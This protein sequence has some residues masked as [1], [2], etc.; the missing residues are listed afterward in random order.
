MSMSMS[1]SVSMYTCS[2]VHVSTPFSNM[3]PMGGLNHGSECLSLSPRLLLSICPSV[4]LSMA[5]LHS[6]GGDRTFSFFMCVSFIVQLFT[7]FTHFTLF[8]EFIFLI[9]NQGPSPRL[10]LFSRH[11]LY[12]LS[13]PI[14]WTK[15]DESNEPFCGRGGTQEREG[16]EE[17]EEREDKGPKGLRYVSRRRQNG[18][19][20]A[21]RITMSD[22]GGVRPLTNERIDA[23]IH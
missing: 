12:L 21:M 23:P 20:V 18:E 9:R 7:H 14:E 16:R 1:M 19:S 10:S 2:W 8:S 4:H 11:T 13:T 22:V 5:Y 3:L 15:K 6:A 17:R